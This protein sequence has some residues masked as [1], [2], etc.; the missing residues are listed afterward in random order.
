MLPFNLKNINFD[1]TCFDKNDLTKHYIEMVN[2]I[3]NYYHVIILSNNNILGT[4]GP[5]WPIH[6]AKYRENEWPSDI[7]DIQKKYTHS[8]YGPTTILI[9]KKTYQSY[10]ST[11]SALK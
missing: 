4:N 9:N 5:K 1:W 8:S 6:V 11:K 10:S 7:Y 2:N 3:S